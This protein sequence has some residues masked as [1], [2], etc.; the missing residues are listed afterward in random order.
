MAIQAKKTPSSPSIWTWLSIT[1]LWGTVFFGTS[2]LTLRISS[3]WLEQGFFNPA[4]P[5]IYSVYAIYFF[6][7]LFLA[8]AAMMIKRKQDPWGE[9]QTRRQQEVLAGKREQ[10]F[11]SF[12]AS[13]VTSFSFTVLT[14]LVFQFSSVF[15]RMTVELAV[16]VVLMAA[17]LNVSAGLAASLLAGLVIF[18]LKKLWG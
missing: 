18:V 5:E 8:L 17:V 4:W 2:V 9:K 10:V 11:V 12:A 3:N 13:I 7:L 15:V 14:A 1:F 6:L 16:P